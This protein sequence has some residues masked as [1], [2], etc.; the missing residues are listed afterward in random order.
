MTTPFRDEL[1]AALERASELEN[2]NEELR[3]RVGELETSKKTTDENVHE[4]LA[5]NH[6]V[7]ERMRREQKEE[8]KP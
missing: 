7:M 4:T 2:E 1:S 6:G 8:E 3:V 5:S